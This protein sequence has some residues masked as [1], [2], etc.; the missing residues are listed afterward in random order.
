MAKLMSSTELA[1]YLGVPL[2]TLYKWRVQK[3]GPR[4][5]RLGRALHWRVEDVEAWLDSR[6]EDVGPT[7]QAG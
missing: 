7:H 2:Q 1:D 3:Q 5:I 6:L 4:A